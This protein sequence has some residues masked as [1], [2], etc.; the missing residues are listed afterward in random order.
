M[1]LVSEA[2]VKLLNG[3][4]ITDIGDDVDE[5]C[6]PGDDDE[7]EPHRNDSSHQEDGLG[8]DLLVD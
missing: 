4:G 5:G 8:D 1:Q 7:A 3:E 6:D 2:L